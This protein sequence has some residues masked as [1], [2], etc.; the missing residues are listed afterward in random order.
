MSDFW[1][2][3]LS[4][5]GVFALAV[6]IYFV[7]LFMDGRRLRRERKKAEMRRRVIKH[8]KDEWIRPYPMGG[9]GPEGEA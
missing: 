6:V 3:V 5:L 1:K 7:R 8:E 9:P 2:I 4:A